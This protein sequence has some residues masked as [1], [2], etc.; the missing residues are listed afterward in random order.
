MQALSGNLSPRR[1]ARARAELPWA[2]GDMGSFPPSNLRSSSRGLQAAPL[3]Q[4]IVPK[5]G[6][7]IGQGERAQ[8]PE[9]GTQEDEGYKEEEVKMRTPL[10]RVPTS[11]SGVLE[12][13]QAPHRGDVG[14]KAVGDSTT[15]GS[16]KKDG[17]LIKDSVFDLE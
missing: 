5:H 11:R 3:A 17:H 12:G 6:T 14:L 2:I 8:E 10:S 4:V 9:V 13:T 7:A 1:P 16:S 15:K